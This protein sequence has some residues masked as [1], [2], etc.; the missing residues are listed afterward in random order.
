MII[1]ILSPFFYNGLLI[2]LVCFLPTLFNTVFFTLYLLILNYKYVIFILVYL[3]LKVILLTLIFKKYKGI[4]YKKANFTIRFILK[5]FLNSFI[6]ILVSSIYLFSINQLYLSIIEGENL[7]IISL[8]IFH[9]ICLV[10]FKYIIEITPKNKFK[11]IFSNLNFRSLDTNLTIIIFLISFL[12]YICIIYIIY[13]TFLSLVLF[14]SVF[15]LNDINLGLKLVI[16]LSTRPFDIFMSNIN[17]LSYIK[18]DKLLLLLEKP[19]YPSL[20]QYMIDKFIFRKDMLLVDERG[21]LN[22]CSC[23]NEH[24]IFPIS[25]I[26]KANSL[27]IADFTPV[28]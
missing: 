7:I 2:K 21:N 18:C 13:Q 22:K 16:I 23:V 15:V 28:Y 19:D 24:N 9:I 8:V 11:L 3:F 12:L 14:F 1:I 27:Y 4:K 26:I 17:I 6:Y 25:D 10:Y 20:K 5:C